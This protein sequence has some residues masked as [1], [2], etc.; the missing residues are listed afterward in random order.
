MGLRADQPGLRLSAASRLWPLRIRPDVSPTDDE[1]FALCAANP[2]LRIERAADG[3]LWVM[4]PT[5][6]ITGRRNTELTFQFARWDRSN[7]TGVVFD[8]STGFVLPNGAQRSPDVAWVARSRWEALRPSEQERFPPLCPD[9]VVELRS[10]TDRLGPLET[11]MVEYVTQGTQLAWLIDPT[12]R[13][14]HVY[15]P[16]RPPHILEAP[17]QVSGDPPMTGFML[18]VAPL[19]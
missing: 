12:T 3:E 6:G 8:S 11:K 18:D 9:V 17:S 2:E 16:E 1:L 15:R 7:D 5:G 13:W 10:S 19:W 4:P 14:V